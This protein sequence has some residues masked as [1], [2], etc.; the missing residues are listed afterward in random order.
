MGV[1]GD[2]ANKDFAFG[3]GLPCPADNVNRKILITRTEVQ[4]KAMEFSIWKECP[5]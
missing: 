3:P 5:F 4:G 1:L 2:A